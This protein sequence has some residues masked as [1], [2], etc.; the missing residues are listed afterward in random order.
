[1]DMHMVSQMDLQY[2]LWVE[3]KDKMVQNQGLLMDPLEIDLEMYLTR[4]KGMGH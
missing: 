4:V 3:I 1:M 2:T